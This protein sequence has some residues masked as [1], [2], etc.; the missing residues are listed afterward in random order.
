MACLRP[1]FFPSASTSS[2]PVVRITS[3][4]SRRRRLIC[5]AATP[6]YYKL[7]K[8]PK[9]ATLQEIKSSYRSLARKVSYITFFFLPELCYATSQVN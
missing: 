9:N 2:I 5:A 1:S 8:L 7:L 3:A 4:S 6:D